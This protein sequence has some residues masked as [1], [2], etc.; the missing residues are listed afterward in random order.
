M[1][2]RFGPTQ[3]DLRF[4]LLGIPVVVHPS[5][6]LLAVLFSWWPERVDLTMIGMACIFISIL[7]HEMGHAILQ[8]KWG[9]IFNIQLH[10][11]GGAASFIPGPGYTPRRSIL[12]SLAGPFAG[13]VL[14]GLA[15]LIQWGAPQI[16]VIYDFLTSDR[17]YAEYFV[18]STE[19]LFYL[20]LIWG[21]FNLLPIMPLDGG[22]VSLE[23]CQ[24]L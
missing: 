21:I 10:L 2:G 20:N 8:R 23:V 6:W 22:H 14:A 12:V 4:H 1:F 19:R 3:F 18:H 13:F 15:W 7:I 16:D 24:L 5:F 9:D 11:Y 17:R